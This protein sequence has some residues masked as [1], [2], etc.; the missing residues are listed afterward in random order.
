MRDKR[1]FKQARPGDHLMIPFECDSCVFMKLK[2]RLPYLSSSSDRL[3]SSCIRRMILDAFWSRET[4][5]VRANTR[6][7]N[8]LI[9]VASLFQMPGPFFYESTLPLHDHCG[10]R[11][12]VSILLLSRNPGKHDKSYT[13]YDMLRTYRATYGNFIRA[14]PQTNFSP[15][16]LGDQNGHYQ[17]LTQDESGSLFFKRFMVGLRSRMG[18]IHKPN[19]AM[20]ID[21]L[22]KLIGKIKEKLSGSEEVLEEQ[23]CF[24][25]ILIYVIISY[26]TA[27]RGPEGFLGKFPFII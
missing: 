20:S 26:V 5:T 11:I 6:R 2:G 12:A 19:L 15:M 21:L 24:S 16:T 23:H 8:K 3:L 25:S 22:L 17:R 9:E 1:D 27:L 7:A 14:A 4:S 18:Q 10:Y 13:Q